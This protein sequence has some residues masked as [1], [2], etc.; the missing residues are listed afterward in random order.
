MVV[1]QH[2]L[3]RILFAFYL[4]YL[5]MP[6]VG[7]ATTSLETLFWGAWI[8]FFVFVVSANVGILLNL[9]PNVRKS[10][11]EKKRILVKQN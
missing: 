1:K 9:K 8:V 6:S 5:A 11:D 2:A 3:L 4:L 7:V 10:Q